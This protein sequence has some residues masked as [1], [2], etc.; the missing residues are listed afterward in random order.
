[1]KKATKLHKKMKKIH[2]ACKGRF[3]HL[4]YRHKTCKIVNFFSFSFCPKFLFILS[5]SGPTF[6]V[7]TLFCPKFFLN[8]PECWSQLLLPFQIHTN[9][10][11]ASF[12]TLIVLEIKR[13]FELVNSVTV[14]CKNVLLLNKA[15]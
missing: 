6:F 5:K 1:M 14:T 10:E 15:I 8:V 9:V 2:C 11:M 12:I 3:V 13:E 4:K 7:R